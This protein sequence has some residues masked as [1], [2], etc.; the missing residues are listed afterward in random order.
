MPRPCS[1]TIGLGCQFPN[2]RINGISPNDPS[3]EDLANGGIR[4]EPELPEHEAI[5]P[6]VETKS[7]FAFA[8]E[9][10]DD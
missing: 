5:A 10:A 1:P 8:D 2:Q 3:A 9:E 6:E 4:R 7:E